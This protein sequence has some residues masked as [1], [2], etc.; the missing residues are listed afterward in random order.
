MG[1]PRAQTFGTRRPYDYIDDARGLAKVSVPIWTT[2]SLMAS[3]ETKLPRLPFAVDLQYYHDKEVIVSGTLQSF[4]PADLHDAWIFFG[5]KAYYLEGPLKGGR[6]GG[7]LRDISLD[8]RFQDIQGWPRRRAEGIDPLAFAKGTG[9]TT[10]IVKEILFHELVDTGLHLR[11]HTFHRLDLSWRVPEPFRARQNVVR[12]AI[13]FGRLASA[14]G[15]IDALAGRRD[16][17]LPSLLW[18]G[19]MP[20]DGK[21]RPAVD[22]ALFQETYVRAF[23]PVRPA[24]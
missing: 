3:W 20:G 4:L 6:D 11:N 18:L 15:K 9:D 19:D 22:G 23:L 16:Q 1:R 5:P 7:P 13:L 10:E 24:E 8:Q 17:P 12:E 2:K 21:T 14:T